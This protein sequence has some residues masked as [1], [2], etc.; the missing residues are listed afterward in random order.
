MMPIELRRLVD[1]LRFMTVLPMPSAG[2]VP[3][4]WLP[5][6]AKYFPLVGALVG[7]AAGAVVLVMS[8]LVP[9]PL[10][11]LLGLSAAI[12]LTG[13]LHEDGLAD[14]ADGLFGGRDRAQRLAIMKDS[15]IGSF[16]VL[17]LVACLALKGASLLSLDQMSIARLFVAGFALSRLAAV[18]T[19]AGLNYAGDPGTAKVSLSAARM[20]GA[21]T[22]LAV[23]AGVVPGLLVVRLPTFLISGA[24]ALAA[25]FIIARLAQRKIGGYT[26]DILGA[27]EQI[28]QTTFFVVAAGVI[29]GPG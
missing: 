2:S 7:I 29:S 3:D 9:E 11:M 21:E 6:S 10:P 19:M 14:S 17:A 13:A 28:C 15:R 16:G 25:A 12:V 27:V 8:L 26:G 18:L 24:V 1:A 20:T 23:A 22:A 4:D 5:R